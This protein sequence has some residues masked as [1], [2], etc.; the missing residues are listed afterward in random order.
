MALRVAKI[1]ACRKQGFILRAMSNQKNP[2]KVFISYSHDSQEHIACVLKL[3]DAL[4]KW[5][6]DC[7]IDQYELAPANW[8]SWMERQIREADFVLVVCTE[9]YC[10]RFEGRETRP[11]GVGWEG[12]VITTQLYEQQQDKAARFIPVIFSQADNEHIPTLLRPTHRHVINVEKL[13]AKNPRADLS[14]ENLYRHLAGMPRVAKPKIGQLVMLP[15]INVQDDFDEALPAAGNVEET[16]INLKEMMPG[17]FAKKLG[18]ELKLPKRESE[19]SPKPQIT[20]PIPALVNQ[21]FTDDLNGV[22]LEMVYVPKG[23]FTMGSNVDDSEKPPH[24]VTVPAFYMGK[25]QIIQAQWKAVMG[26]KLKPSFNGDDL[27]MESVSWEDAKEF[28]KKL[29]QMTNKAYRL[30]SEAEWEYACR[31]GTTSDYAGELNDMAWYSENADQKTH[32]VGQKKPNAFG[33]YDMH[34]NVWEWCEDV[35]HDNYKKAPTDGSAWLSGGDSSLRVFRGGSWN[36][37]GTYCRSALCF[38]NPP[39]TRYDSIGFRVVVSAWTPST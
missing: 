19:L 10:R 24:E 28:C 32:P 3:S 5:G 26:D 16:G 29:A 9:V 21:N 7:H 33:L 17:L 27:P 1:F 13:D 2:P 14:T 37:K 38:S 22:K 11:T 15:P 39:G 34:G 6:F 23:K 35:W 30:P 31:A 12:G 36:L 8:M 25:F 18:N 4:C 20:T